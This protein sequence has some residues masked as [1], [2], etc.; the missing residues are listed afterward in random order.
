MLKQLEGELRNGVFCA[1]IPFPE[2]LKLVELAY[3]DA[4]LK[5]IIPGITTAGSVV[6]VPPMTEREAMDADRES[7][8]QNGTPAVSHWRGGWRHD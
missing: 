7:I 6:I 4:K 5:R 1:I 2:F 3:G 8:R